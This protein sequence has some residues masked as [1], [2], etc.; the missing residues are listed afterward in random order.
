MFADYFIILYVTLLYILKK[1]DMKYFK[2][3][4]ESLKNFI[5]LRFMVLITEWCW[6][7]TKDVSFWGVVAQYSFIALSEEL[8]TYAIHRKIHQHYKL[9]SVIHK[10]HH[11]YYADDF[12]LAF[13]MTILEI[14]TFVYPS[15]MAGGWLIY[16]AG[17]PVSQYALELWF[18]TSIIFFLWSHS[19]SKNNT[20]HKIH[21]LC[22]RYNFGSE[23]LDNLLK[24]K[25]NELEK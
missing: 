8:L 15:V 25:K 23:W 13:Y 2:P 7:P 6:Q 20:F 1:P 9:Y 22:P 21:H 16:F 17:F 19:G 3:R 18:S 12:T 5:I 11:E 4:G 24:K 10:K 14:L